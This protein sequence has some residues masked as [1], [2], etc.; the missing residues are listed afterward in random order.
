MLNKLI[1]WII[2]N[3]PYHALVKNLKKNDWFV[4]AF[5]VAGLLICIPLIFFLNCVFCSNFYDLLI[6]NLIDVLFG[7]FHI[8]LLLNK[9][10]K[11]EF[12]CLLFSL[13]NG[14]MLLISS[15]RTAIL[16]KKDN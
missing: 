15:F 9:V 11:F 5:F 14:K 4:V 3:F 7:V 8:M 13:K 10:E 2:Y 6:F 16:L 12:I 1:K